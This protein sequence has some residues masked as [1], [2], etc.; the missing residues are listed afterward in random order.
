MMGFRKPVEEKLTG[1]YQVC[2]AVGGGKRGREGT[3]VAVG[4]CGGKNRRI[5]SGEEKLGCVVASEGSLFAFPMEA[6]SIF[7]KEDIINE[8]LGEK[9]GKS[10]VNKENM[11]FFT[12]LYLSSVTLLQLPGLFNLIRLDSL[13]F[14]FAI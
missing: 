9:I 1:S 8:K 12:M 3:T 10:S 2:G 4:L 5:I 14:F 11:I 6:L 13:P 7:L